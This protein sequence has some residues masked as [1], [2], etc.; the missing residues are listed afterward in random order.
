MNYIQRFLTEQQ[1]KLQIALVVIALTICVVTYVTVQTGFLHKDHDMMVVKEQL[2]GHGIIVSSSS[3]QIQNA[4]VEHVVLYSQEQDGSHNKIQRNGVFVRYP[5]AVATVLL[6]HG[7]MCDKQDEAFLRNLFPRGAYNIM[8]FDFRAHGENRKGQFCTLGKDESYDVIAAGKFIKQ[9][10]AVKD[11][12]LYVYGFSMGAVAAIEAQSKEPELFHAM[13]L[14]CPFDSSMNVLK[15]GLE[16]LKVSLFGYK[17]DVPGKQL[18]EK[19]SFHPYVQSFVRALLKTIANLDA[20]DIPLR[21]PPFSPAI[22]AEKIKIP[23]LFIHCKKDEK[24]PIEAVTKVY[25]SVAS[26]YKVLWL[27]NGT[28]HFGSY[29]HNPERY[30]DTV[31]GFLDLAVA[32]DLYIT[33]K[34]EIIEDQE[35]HRKV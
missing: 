35:E 6:C 8:S 14:D 9:H 18:L 25:S 12:P 11:L 5:D 13:I 27:T 31:R 4:I 2:E 32:G 26:E 19:Y 1:K 24:V 34:S 21:V 30:T 33:K 22:S 29:F 17:F 20:R 15:R 16:N 7:L 28:K 10:T 23:I 3:D